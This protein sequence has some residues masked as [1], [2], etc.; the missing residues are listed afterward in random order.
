MVRQI[1]AVCLLRL[2]V[3]LPSVL[4]HN[5][6]RGI[7]STARNIDGLFLP[8][9]AEKTLP[10]TLSVYDTW[11]FGLTGHVGWISSAAV[12]HA[13][14][15][16]GSI[17]IWLPVSIVSILLNLQIQSL[18]KRRLDIAG[19]TPNFTAQLWIVIQPLLAMLP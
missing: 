5:Q 14:L 4:F 9:S 2:T 6:I 13:A 1:I 3:D 10:R 11:G 15:G 18:G 12:I 16:T 8:F 7:V 17:L 19:G